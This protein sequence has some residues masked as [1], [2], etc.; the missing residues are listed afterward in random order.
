MSAANLL[1][2]DHELDADVLVT[3]DDQPAK[4]AVMALVER[5]KNLRA[6][7]AGG[8]PS[9]KYVEGITALLVGINRRHKARS[10]IKIIGLG[11]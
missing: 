11:E 9:S 1:D 3:G 7:D 2:P 4:E 5:M 10:E 8:L 6:I